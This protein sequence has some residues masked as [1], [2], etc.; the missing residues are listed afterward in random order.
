MSSVEADHETVI[1]DDETSDAARP[2]GT[3]GGCVSGGTAVASRTSTQ[4]PSPSL[5]LP[6]GVK[7]RVPVFASGEPGIAVKVPFA[8]S[9]HDAYAG[10]ARRDMSTV[11]VRTVGM[12]AIASAPSG[13]RAA[14]R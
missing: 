13:V 4:S 5:L 2:V 12:Y 8:G 10:P 3:D 1:S 11:I 6:G 14:V 9:Y 7:V